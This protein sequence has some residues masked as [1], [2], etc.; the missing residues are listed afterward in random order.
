M[1]ALSGFPPELILHTVSFLTRLS[2]LDKHRHLPEHRGVGLG[3]HISEPQL[4]PDLPSINALSQTCTVFH[5]TLNQCLYDVCARV[6]SLGRLAL[7]F[8]LKQD[9]ETVFDRFVSAGVSFDSKFYFRGNC[10]GLLQ[11]AAAMGLQGMVVKL[12]RMHGEDLPVR[13]YTRVSARAHIYGATALD[14]A[15]QG[16]HVEIVRLLAPIPRLSFLFHIAA[17]STRPPTNSKHADCTSALPSSDR[18]KLGI[19]RFLNT[20]YRREQTL[21]SSTVLSVLR[22]TLLPVRTLL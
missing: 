3:S 14:Y 9:M 2:I 11:V 12:L 5:S 6:D 1:A 8:A 17:A 16:Q 15:A 4:I 13:A 22:F 10:R 21:I 7:F 19:S 20:S 18:Q